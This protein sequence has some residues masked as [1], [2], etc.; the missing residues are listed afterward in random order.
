MHIFMHTA[1]IFTLLSIVSLVSWTLLFL[2]VLYREIV[3]IDFLYYT[4]KMFKR[5]RNVSAFLKQSYKFMFLCATF[6][7]LLY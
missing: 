6:D 3:F 7:N 1:V 4:V 5:K 2:L